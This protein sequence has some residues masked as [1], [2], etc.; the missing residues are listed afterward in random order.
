MS[1]VHHAHHVWCPYW[2]MSLLEVDF[3]LTTLVCFL[4]ESQLQALRSCDIPSTCWSE[5]ARYIQLQRAISLLPHRHISS[6][7]LSFTPIAS[8]IIW[9]RGYLGGCSHAPPLS[10][11]PWRPLPQ[12]V[13][14][15]DH[16]I[17]TTPTP[18]AMATGRICLIRTAPHCR[19][20]PRNIRNPHTQ[21][22]LLLNNPQRR[23]KVHS[24][25]PS[26][27][28]VLTA[29][30]GM[31][32]AVVVAARSNQRSLA[33]SCFGWASRRTSRSISL[34]SLPSFLLRSGLWGMRRHL[35]LSHEMWR[36]KSSDASTQTWRL[37]IWP[38]I[39]LWWSG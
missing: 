18:T 4:Q 19:E 13:S 39:Q 26:K 12:A 9:M 10:L 32:A 5:S 27:Q 11:A 29:G 8:G 37:K 28:K 17:K 34:H 36:W 24:A 22:L 14:G 16:T 33:W 31:E 25:L 15:N 20:G 30:R 1:D 6:H 3:F 38:G 7:L 2:F 35:A 21:C 23:T